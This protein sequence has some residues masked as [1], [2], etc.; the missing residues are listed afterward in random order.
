MKKNNCKMTFM[1]KRAWKSKV[2]KVMRATVFAILVSVTQILAVNTYS[3]NTLLTLNLKNTMVKDVLGHIQENSEFFFIYDASVIDVQKEISIK[4]KNKLIPEILDEIFREMNVVYKIDDRQIALT[5]TN[6]LITE[7][8]QQRTISGTV[9]D[10]S[11][12]PLPGVTVLV[13]GT[14]QGTVTNADGDYALTNIP[15]DATLQFSFVGM[16]TQEVVV[17]SQTSIN[18]TMVVDAIG[19]EEVVAIGYGTQ[20]K[21]TVTGAISDIKTEDLVKNSAADI[22]NSIAGRL[23]GVI[24]VQSNAEP[25]DDAAQLFIRG[26]GSLNNNTPLVL[27]DGVERE[28]NRI[29]PNNIESMSVLKDASATAVYGVRGANGVIII[30]TKRGEESKPTLTYNGYYG[31][32]TPTRT[33][34]YLN[35]YDF[36]RLYNE[37]QEN[38]G[39]SPVYTADDLQKYKD[40]SDPYGHPDNNWRKEVLRSNAPIQRHSIALSGGTKTIRYYA[41]FGILDQEGILPNVNYKSYSFMTNIDADVTPTTKISFNLSGTRENRHYPGIVGAT[42]D[43]G[44][45]GLINYLPPNAFP[46]HNEDGSFSSLWGANPLGEVTESGYKLWHNNTLQSSFTVEQKLNFITDG[47]S[48]KVLGSFDPGFWDEKNWYTPYKTFQKTDTGYDEIAAGSLPHLYENFYKSRSTS[49]EAHLNYSKTFKKHSVSALLLYTQSAFYDDNFNAERINYQ[50]SA[51]D[52]L[53]AGPIL[54]ARNY[55]SGSESGRE[56]YVGRVTYGYDAK[57]LLEA[58]FGYNGSENFPNSKRYGFFPSASAGWVLSNEDFFSSLKFINFLKIRASYGQVGNDKIGGQRFLY[59]QL[60]NFGDG[61][62]FGGNTVI[63]AQTISMG[64]LS[65]GNVTWEKAKKSNIGF[66]AQFLDNMFGLKVDVFGEKRDNI[67]WYRNASLPETFGASLPAENFAKVNNKGFE[68]ELTHAHKIGDFE[69]SIAGNFTFAR[70]KIVFVDEAENVPDW[71]KQTGHPM[72]QFFGYVSEGLYMTQEQIANH[73]KIEGVEP[74]LGQIMYKDVSGDGII[75]PDDITA[76]GRSKIPEIMYGISLSAKYKDFDFSTLVQGAGNNDVYFY[77]EAAWPFLYGSSALDNILNRWTPENPNPSFPRLTTYKEQYYQE[78]SSYWLKS[79]AYWRLKNIELGYTLP[80]SLLAR[81]SIE[82]F[83]IYVSSTNPYTHAK[84][85]NW[86]P[87][88]PNGGG[89]YSPQMTVYNLGV[90][91]TF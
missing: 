36:A 87:E 42:V 78:L 68:I 76:I 81:L 49:F 89:Y 1:L 64:S 62:V 48:M 50:T 58:N 88:A 12:E 66:D 43:G 55:G 45:Y 56:G 9:T 60:F 34:N 29:D 47:L 21:A 91:V 67:L 17:G 28:F 3:Q 11:G 90:N 7:I 16:R 69:Y 41:S 23:S 4:A 14:T 71:Q 6:P 10:E 13:K 86:D 79:A 27:V 25:G 26:Q 31:I 40:H 37:A 82:K 33:P 59:K 24:A 73:P 46:L 51:V 65:N 63:P 38:D 72:G 19:I 85:K 54:N 61:T 39:D 52:Q 32:Q 35:S 75:S 30:T 74:L 84:F 22:S 44:V 53:F 83:R 80:K 77:Y 57:Y 15:E 70:N 2:L 5:K 20:K 8:Q 18:V